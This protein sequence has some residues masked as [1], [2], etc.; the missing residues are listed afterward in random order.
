MYLHHNTETD[1]VKF[2]A[3]NLSGLIISGYHPSRFLQH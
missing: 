1:L 3:S 2:Q